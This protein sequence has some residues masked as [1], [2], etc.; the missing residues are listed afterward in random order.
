[1]KN[2][3][4]CL[5][6]K[7]IHM[8]IH[9]HTHAHKSWRYISDGLHVEP[10][11][12]NIVMQVMHG[13]W[14]WVVL[15]SLGPGVAATRWSPLWKAHLDMTCL[16]RV[17][18]AGV[19][20]A[21]GPVC[22]SDPRKAIR[23]DCMA[24]RGHTRQQTATQIEHKSQSCFHKCTTHGTNLANWGSIKGFASY[25]TAWKADFSRSHSR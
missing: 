2:V 21:R 10:Q 14:A 16:S 3:Y 24:T 18:A 23:S 8:V 13:S 17:S 12:E 5:C 6:I 7:Y 15:I 11:P 20:V 1:M 19:T 25:R 22:D 9:I 4:V